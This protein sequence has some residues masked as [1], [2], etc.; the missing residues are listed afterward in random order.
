[1][2][3]RC[4]NFIIISGEIDLNLWA[5]FVLVERGLDFNCKW[6]ALPKY[7]NILLKKKI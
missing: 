5:K 7:L 6:V 3:H 1:L 4:S 2:E